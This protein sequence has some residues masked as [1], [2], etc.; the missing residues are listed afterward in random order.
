MSAPYVLCG[1]THSDLALHWRLTLPMLSNHPSI[2]T[3]V[4]VVAGAKTS[5]DQYEL[6]ESS[7]Q[8]KYASFEFSVGGLAG[9]GRA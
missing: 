5:L 1:G 7:R 6:A 3:S 8:R 2:F 4:M 9:Q